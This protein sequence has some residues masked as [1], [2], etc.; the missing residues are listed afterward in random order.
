V[1]TFF[2]GSGDNYACGGFP[3]QASVP[4]GGTQGYIYNAIQSPWIAL[5]GNRSALDLRFLVYRDLPLENLV[6]YRVR[7][8]SMKG[9]SPVPWRD[10]DE[11]FY[12]GGKDWQRERLSIGDLIEAGADSVQIA[13]DVIDMCESWCGILGDGNCHSHAPLIDDVELVHAGADGPQFYVDPID[14]FQDNFASD[15]TTTGTVRVDIARDINPRSNAAIRP[16]DSLVVSV[17]EATA[18]LDNHQTGVASSGPAVYLHVKDIGAKSGTVITGDASRWPVASTGGGWTALR[19]DTIRAGTLAT[20]P[21]NSSARGRFCVDLNDALYTPGDT[22]TFYLSA[23]DALGRTTYWSE[24][25]GITPNEQ[26]A[27]DV[28]GEMTCLPTG[29][30]D[31]SYILFV[32]DADCTPRHGV[33]VTVAYDPLCG[34]P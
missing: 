2:A 11:V 34:A 1:W 18:G 31:G 26:D 30:S 13:F 5:S 24:F 12:G 8:R 21:V 23:R 32:D 22:I 14:L 4:L 17:G 29:G 10:H 20:D 33:R 6:F 3:S 15:G 27:R 9:G 16:G 25:T 19:M 7:V 28:A